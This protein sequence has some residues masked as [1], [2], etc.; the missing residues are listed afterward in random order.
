MFFFLYPII[1][2]CFVAEATNYLNQC[3]QVMEVVIIGPIT[4]NYF[5]QMRSFT[6]K[7]K[8]I[9]IG[10]FNFSMSCFSIRF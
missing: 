10:L 2:I 8:L 3:N 7:L 1:F 4:E 9:W 6:L 5:G